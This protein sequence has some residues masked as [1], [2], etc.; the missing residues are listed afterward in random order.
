MG[1][2]NNDDEDEEDDIDDGE[3]TTPEE[4]SAAVRA[5]MAEFR[6]LSST[7]P[8]LAALPL[9]AS[10]NVMGEEY[11][12]S[13]TVDAA[14]DQEI[15]DAEA[16]M[17]SQDKKRQMRIL[18]TL[19]FM[20]EHIGR[21]LS[22]GPGM[23]P[24]NVLFDERES[25]GHDVFATTWM[26]SQMVIRESLDTLKAEIKREISLLLLANDRGNKHGFG[27]IE[28]MKSL[29]K[30]EESMSKQDWDRYLRA[31]TSMNQIKSK[32][33]KRG[34]GGGGGGGGGRKRNRRNSA[35]TPKFP[36]CAVCGKAGHVAGDAACKAAARAPAQ[37]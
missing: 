1:G 31:S 2:G 25:L 15:R 11:L 21:M 10:S 19:Q 9:S 29:Q 18:M 8:A 16:T 3:A 35:N 7:N 28:R 33:G 20:Q 34:G 24:L 37:Q 6:A 27:T 36:K 5:K 4:A 14:R 30:L 22:A 26:A 17:T 13:S 32:A 12:R 23:L